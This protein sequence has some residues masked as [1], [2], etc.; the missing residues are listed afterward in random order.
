[1]RARLAE[2]ATE[3]W[4]LLA[5]VVA[6]CACIV[7]AY[8][9]WDRTGQLITGWSFSAALLLL[10]AVGFFVPGKLQAGYYTGREVSQ[11]TFFAALV[12]LFLCAVALVASGWWWFP[13]AS[14][15]GVVLLLGLGGL[16]VAP[17][18]AAG[19]EAARAMPSLQFVQPWW[20]LCLGA[21]P[22]AVWMSYGSLA[23][24]GPVRRWLALVARCTLVALL[25]L[26]LAEPRLR[27]PNENVAVLFVVDR[28]LSVPQDIDPTTADSPGGVVDRRW[29]R[30]REFI[31][32]SVAHRGHDHRNDQS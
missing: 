22:L 12:G 10:M 19:L 1:M 15:L 27:T 2:L 23:G 20:L 30:I 16:I 29:Q 9:R 14:A 13:L 21:V 26:A 4:L 31:T 24:L 18:Q 17:V 8:R 28:S 5:L 25:A 7:P 3:N 6:F 11:W 32:E